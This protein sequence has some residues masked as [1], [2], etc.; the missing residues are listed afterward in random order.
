MTS[1][2]VPD[3]DV[4]LVRLGREI[5]LREGRVGAI[6]SD[7]KKLKRIAEQW[8]LANDAKMRSKLERTQSYASSRSAKNR[9][10]CVC[11]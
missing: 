8:L 3:L 7:P 5:E 2:E 9:G 1:T 11:W 4:L 6:P 10:T